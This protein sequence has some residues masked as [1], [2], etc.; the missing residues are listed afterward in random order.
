MGLDSLKSSVTEY[1]DKK[2]ELVK[3]RQFF[4]SEQSKVD[5]LSA[6]TSHLDSSI[7]CAIQG[8]QD[9]FSVEREGLDQ[10]ADSLQHEKDELT[11]RINDEQIKLDTVQRKIDSLTGKKYTGG[12]DAAS[13]KCDSLLAELDE[14]LKDID[15]DGYAGSG[16]GIGEDISVNNQDNK[17]E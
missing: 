6:V 16:G 8:I 2:Q 11:K 3:E 14:M 1:S 15:S 13:Q 9:E 5:L 12:L 4:D 7:V 10:Q 17:R